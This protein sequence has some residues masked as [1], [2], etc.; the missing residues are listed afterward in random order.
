VDPNHSE[1]SRPT[2]NSGLS[3]YGFRSAIPGNHLLPYSFY[4]GYVELLNRERPAWMPLKVSWNFLRFL[5]AGLCNRQYWSKR[6]PL[7]RH[8]KATRTSISKLWR[9]ILKG[10]VLSFSFLQ[11]E[12]DR[13]MAASTVTRSLPRFV[14]PWRRP[15][16]REGSYSPIQSSALNHT[17]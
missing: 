8:D 5:R 7:L 9:H 3:N 13:R 11:R 17:R 4:S 2:R 14:V 15:D 16:V 12:P 1:H 10:S 6:K